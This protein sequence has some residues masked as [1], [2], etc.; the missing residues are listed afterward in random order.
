MQLGSRWQYGHAPH[1]AVPG[2]LHEAIAAAE[3]AA[4]SHAGA[5]SGASWTLTWL[6]GRPRVELTGGAGEELADLSVAADGRVTARGVTA[7]SDPA[8]GATH[9]GD[10][11]PL[12]GGDASDSGSDDD[13]WLN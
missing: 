3:A 11:R 4:R 5:A 13:D 12:G 2:V 1:P 8:E 6:E 9:G 7:G 10:G